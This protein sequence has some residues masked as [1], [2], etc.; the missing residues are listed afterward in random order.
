[1][2]SKFGSNAT[3]HSDTFSV[4]KMTSLSTVCPEIHWNG[5]TTIVVSTALQDASERITLA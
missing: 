2:K 5:M 1:M 4:W 3:V